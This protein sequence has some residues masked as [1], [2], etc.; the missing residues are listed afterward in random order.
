MLFAF[1]QLFFGPHGENQGLSK[2]RPGGA[3]KYW[4]WLILVA[5]TRVCLVNVA[6]T[7][8]L[9]ENRTLAAAN[10]RLTLAIACLRRAFA[11]GAVAQFAARR[12]SAIAVT[13]AIAAGTPCLNE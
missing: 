2:C 4:I 8:A 9:A 11:Q 7:R 13:G 6:S 10:P 1:S 5:S 12:D 3:A